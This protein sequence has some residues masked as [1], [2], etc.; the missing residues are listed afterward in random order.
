[1]TFAQVA[2][3]IRALKIPELRSIEAADL[4]RGGKVPA[5]KLSLMIRVTFQSGETTFTD[6]QINDFSAR[7]VSALETRLGASL[8]TI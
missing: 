5:G 8:R 6:A 4:F 3:A 7:I 1:V 2:D